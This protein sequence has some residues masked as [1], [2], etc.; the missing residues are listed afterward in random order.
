MGM[1]VISAKSFGPSSTSWIMRVYPFVLSGTAYWAQPCWSTLPWIE[2]SQPFIY[3]WIYCWHFFG[4]KWI[5]TR[6][7]MIEASFQCSTT[8]WMAMWWPIVWWWICRKGWVSIVEWRRRRVGL[9]LWS[10]MSCRPRGS[11][12]IF[13]FQFMW[14]WFQAGMNTF[15]L[16]TKGEFLEYNLWKK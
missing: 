11:H 3:P 15:C 9:R 14:C 6:Y 8:R 13:N 4:N 1:P 2:L 5:K 7:V 12:S 16:Y 10:L